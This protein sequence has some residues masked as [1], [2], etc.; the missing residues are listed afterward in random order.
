VGRRGLPVVA[1]VVM[2]MAA[3][4]PSHRT[5]TPHAHVV[6][7]PSR[8][9]PGRWAESTA[10][11]QMLGAD[12][13]W[14]VGL[15]CPGCQ[16]PVDATGDGGRT[17]RRIASPVGAAAADAVFALSVGPGPQLWLWSRAHHN[18]LGST[19]FR[20]LD[21][22][23]SWSEIRGL[24]GIL[25][26]AVSPSRVWAVEETCAPAGCADRV[27]VSADAGARWTT[28]AH[29][30][31]LVPDPDATQLVLRD[32][33]VAWLL[34]ATMTDG[35]ALASTTDG[36]RTWASAGVPP[37]RCAGFP[38]VLA[39]AD[40][41]HLWFACAGNGATAQEQREVATSADGG[42][43]WT[44]VQGSV[45]DGHLADLAAV[46]PTT[47]FIGQC[48]GSILR[49]VDGGRTWAEAIPRGEGAPLDGCVSPVDFVDPSHG[50][51]AGQDPAGAWIVW[52]TSDGGRT[53][54]A[55]PLG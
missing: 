22:G 3:C 12:R 49:S 30:P 35:F 4:S 21:G 43:S 20:S 55:A 44:V 27:I 11:L 36:G 28:P 13:G 14:A 17:W 5:A 50:W 16:V 7:V 32:D 51:A 48:R 15:A 34:S 9:A 25:A 33:R 40:R 6:A 8:P 52:R 54:A 18:G 46:S 10:G 2:V 37:K 1:A 42:R 53:W 45:V 29:Q 39:A 19:V 24:G 47:A 26:L 41:S 38:A 31:R 23:A